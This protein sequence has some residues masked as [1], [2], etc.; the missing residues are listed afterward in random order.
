LK[1]NVRKKEWRKKTRK[2]KQLKQ[3]IWEGRMNYQRHTF[4]GMFFN[5]TH[6]QP[7]THVLSI[8]STFLSFLSLKISNLPTKNKNLPR[9]QF[10]VLDLQ[11]NTNLI[12][13]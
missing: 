1:K 4:D 12:T 3:R 8:S 6:I 5:Q 13:F 11:N 2:N 9:Y 7:N 10:V